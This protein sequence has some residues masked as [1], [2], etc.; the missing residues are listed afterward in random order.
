LKSHFRKTPQLPAVQLI[1]PLLAQQLN[2]PNADA[3]TLIPV[4]DVTPN[5]G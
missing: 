4:D 3:Q 5:V 2:R 1:H